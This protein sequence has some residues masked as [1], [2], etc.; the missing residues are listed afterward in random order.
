MQAKV[1]AVDIN[2]TSDVLAPESGVKGGL[3]LPNKERL[4]FRTPEKKSVLGTAFI[5]CL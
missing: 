2:R 3:N 1:H 4:L 5:G